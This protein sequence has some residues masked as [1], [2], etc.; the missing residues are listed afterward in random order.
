[1]V[2]DRIQ[3]VFL[4]LMLNAIEAMPEGGQIKISATCTYDPDGVAITFTDNDGGIASEN[5]PHLFDAF[6][7]TKPD[8]VGLGLYITKFIVESHNGHIEVESEPDKGTT[9]TVWLP[10]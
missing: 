10:A 8:G 6:Y 1:M 3:Q 4:N 2:R 5:L 9:F 7:T